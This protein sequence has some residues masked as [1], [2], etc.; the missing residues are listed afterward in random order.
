MKLK[1]A[2]LLAFALSCPLVFRAQTG[3]TFLLQNGFP[4]AKGQSVLQVNDLVHAH[5]TLGLSERFS[6][7][8]GIIPLGLILEE[9]F[10]IYTLSMKYALPT[11]TDWLHAGLCFYHMGATYVDGKE[12]G[13]GFIEE[14]E[15]GLAVP[16]GVLTFGDKRR[17][18]TLAG[19][20]TYGYYYF[21]DSTRVPEDD[22]DGFYPFPYLGL[23][24]YLQTGKKVALITENHYFRDQSDHY[25]ILS[26]G[27][28]F[29]SGRTR[30][31]LG[32]ALLLDRD[33]Q[34]TDAYPLPWLAFSFVFGQKTAAAQVGE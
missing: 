28:R 4:L 34:Y 18:I 26:A 13:G 27:V 1:I 24:A 33:A 9:E 23:S 2:A 11:Q 16:Y 14:W 12:Y 20:A 29:G 8:A 19:G 32:G 25:G 15:N 30:L 17:N 21:D 6:L 5:Y 31:D 7:G 3:Q 22:E 10:F